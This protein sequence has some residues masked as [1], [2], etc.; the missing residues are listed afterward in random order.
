MNEAPT[1]RFK[2]GVRTADEPG[3]IR[4]GRSI[5]LNSKRH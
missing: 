2:P 3:P 1:S 5:F 4:T